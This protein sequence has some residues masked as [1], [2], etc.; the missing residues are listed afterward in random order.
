M[1]NLISNLR[2]RLQFGAPVIVVTGLPRSGTSMVMRMLQAGGVAV[3][4]DGERQAD[5]DNPLGYF[6]VERV[7][8]LAQEP[9]KSWLSQSRGKAIKVISHLL[10][11]LPHDNYYSVILCERDLGE[12]LKSQNVMLQRRDQPNPIEDAEARE[13]YERHLAHI[14]I[15]MKIKRN[16]EFLPVRYDEAISN[17][18]AFAERLNA[19]LGGRLNVDRMVEVVD[20]K[21]YRNRKERAPVARA[22]LSLIMAAAALGAALVAPD[23]AHA[24]VGPGAGFALVGSFLA[25]LAAVASS[26]LSLVLWPI[27]FVLRW[28]R[29]RKA[30]S[31]ASAR[32]VVV[33][34]LDGLDP[35]L[36]EQWMAEGHLPNLS[37]LAKSGSFTRLGTT[38]PAISP[39]A[40]SSFMTGVDPARHNIF[41][42]LDRDVRTY[43]PRLSSSDI[44]PAPRTIRVG[45]WL[46]PVGR[47][48]INNMRKSKAFWRILGEHGIPS[49]ILRVP[50][51]FP[52]EKFAGALL[53]AMCIPDLRGTL[54][55]VSPAPTA[56]CA[57]K[58]NRWRS[59]SR[60]VRSTR[61]S[62]LAC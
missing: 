16:M 51:T 36:A 34:G 52:P 39:V 32:R 24:Y 43:K 13:H 55:P 42:F 41:D 37:A 38:Y 56:R 49:N 62:R 5:E 60:S 11:S 10:Q 23:T 57:P 22:S 46:I 53:S 9:D 45:E 25:L 48:I 20:S 19:F 28:R 12:V 40:W 61:P 14:R 33:L 2:R 4:T 30:M 35:T 1:S 3:T 54:A 7:K 26:I 27:R 47:P 59:L 17:P 44:R 29:R 18:R 21:L 6:E 15:F 31:R 8:R 50:L 58:R